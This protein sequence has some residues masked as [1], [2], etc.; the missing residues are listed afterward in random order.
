MNV[1]VG[2]NNAGKSSI[3][4]AIQFAIS[5]AQTTTLEPNI[6]WTGGALS[7]SVAP[8]QLVYS[9]LRDVSALAPGGNLREAREDGISVAFKESDTETEVLVAKGRN[10]NLT[11]RI[12]GQSLG[13]RLQRIEEPYSI[14]VPGLAGIPAVEE[15]KTPGIVRKAA[16]R[17]DA[18]NVFRNIL[19]L[20]KQ[21]GENWEHFIA[22]L[23]KVFPNLQVDVRFNPNRDEHINATVR[24]ATLELPIDAVGT[25]VLQ[26]IQILSYVN[27]YRPKMLILDEPD[28]HLHPNNQRKLAKILLDLTEE[29]DLQV[30]LSTHSRHLID[31]LSDHSKMHWI[32]SGQLVDED[33]YDNVNV[34]M[35]IGALDKG[36]RLLQGSIKYVFLTEDSDIGGIRALLQSSGYNLDDVDIWSYKGCTKVDI[37]L[38]L[39]SFIRKHAPLTTVILH[40]DRDYLNEEEVE[41]FRSVIESDGIHCFLTDGTDVESHFLRAAHINSIYPNISIEQA[42]AIILDSTSEVQAGTMEKFINS[43][44]ALEIRKVGGKEINPGRI[45]ADAHEAYTQD[46]VR[47]R[48]GKKVLGRVRNKLQPLIHGRVNILVPSEAIKSEFL[49]R[50][51]EHSLEQQTR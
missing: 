40:R 25:G 18:N 10:K 9:P 28:S 15:Y 37:A 44:T 22:D 35:D 4:Q 7:T 2:S 23:G 6:R 41:Q 42:E 8:A 24:F 1:I 48:H 13:E 29:G 5:A 12:T 20:L 27:L 39:N 19:W 47:Y 14:Y 21:D 46:V 31:E 51:L 43:R 38:V 17:G 30:L 45:S 11:V 34:L 26:A 50:V 32:Q 33:N 3:L 36:D 49:S 16:A